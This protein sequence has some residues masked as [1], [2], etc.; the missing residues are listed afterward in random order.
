MKKAAS[1][2]LSEQAIQVIEETKRSKELTSNAE[3]L[4]AII[5]A[6]ARQQTLPEE[7]LTLYENRYGAELETLKQ[8]TRAMET[9]LAILVDLVNSLTIHFGLQNLSSVEFEPSPLYT[10]ARDSQ[11]SRLARK[12]QIHD[13]K[14]RN[15]KE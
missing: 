1:Y 11:K 8:S 10:Q 4:E 9:Q 2:R 15:Y 14:H 12:K 6:Y 3:A 7:F 13:H 5:G